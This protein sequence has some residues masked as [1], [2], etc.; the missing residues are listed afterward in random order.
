[1]QYNQPF[2]DGELDSP[3]SLQLFL[4]VQ[5]NCLRSWNVYLSLSGF[6]SKL[7][8]PP[9]VVA[10]QD[11][12]VYRRKLPSFQ[13]YTYSPPPCSGSSKPRVSCYV[14]SD[15]FKSITRLPRFFARGDIMALDLFIQDG[16]FHLSLTYFSIVNSYCTKGGSNNTSTVPPD[17]IFPVLSQ[18]T[19]CFQ[20][21]PDAMGLRLE[22]L[23][24]NLDVLA[25]RHPD[26]L[27]NRKHSPV[28][29]SQSRPPHLRPP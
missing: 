2:R 16:F 17:L 25:P 6:F 14:F 20:K 21:S 23:V 11:P 24:V 9:S 22:D 12:P 29:R 3:S 15:F 10:L 19:C 4:L 5:H 26:T 8:R 13:L 28:E 27:E 1:M 7:S 18:A